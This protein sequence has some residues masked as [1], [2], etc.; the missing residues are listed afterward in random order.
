MDMAAA[1][2]W[3]SV[4]HVTWHIVSRYEG[5]PAISSNSGG[6][7]GIGLAH[8]TDMVEIDVTV[9]WQNDN[10]I[11][12]APVIKNTPSVVT[13]P[14]D[15]SPSCV[16]PVLKRPFEYA[17]FTAV[18]Q[19]LIG[20]LHLTVTRTFPDVTVSLVCSKTTLAP[21]KTTREEY[22]FAP[23]QP[24]ILAMSISDKNTTISPDK[25]SLTLQNVSGFPGWVWTLTPTPR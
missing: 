20:G 16:A 19:G 1:Q 4:K 13:N 11:V 2:K 15:S 22:E 8:V 24:T 17:T 7:G 18:T 23:P 25:K 6:P 5:D 9:D 12:G 21:A 10:T 14:R 3:F